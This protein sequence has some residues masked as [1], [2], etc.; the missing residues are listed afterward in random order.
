MTLPGA[1]SSV[2]ARKARPGI[3]D[4]GQ[5]E[6]HHLE[7]A[8]LLGGAETV[9]GGAQQA[10]R[11][12]SFALQAEHRVDEMLQGL[13]TREGAVLG[14]VAHEDHRDPLLLGQ[15]H[16]HESALA[17]LPDTAGRAFQLVHG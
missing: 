14:D 8:H 13:G 10:E 9:L 11:R 12:R 17:N 16:E 1:C 4:L 5:S 7:D 2:A 3:G 15:F 6:F